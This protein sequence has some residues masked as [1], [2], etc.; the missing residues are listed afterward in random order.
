M[1]EKEKIEEQGCIVG[2]GGLESCYVEQYSPGPASY[3]HPDIPALLVVLQYFTQL[4]VHLYLVNMYIHSMYTVNNFIN[5][6]FVSGVH[7]ASY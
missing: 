4:E 7:V 1:I 5:K 6:T 2:I 3:S